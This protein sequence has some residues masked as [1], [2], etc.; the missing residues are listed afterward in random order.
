M[1]QTPIADPDDARLAPYRAVGDPELL[2]D[3]G[4]FAAEGRFVVERLLCESDYRV[5]SVLV[6]PASAN[7]LD[8]VLTD[9]ASHAPVYVCSPDLL[10]RITGFDFHRGC[11]ALAHRPTDTDSLARVQARLKH[12]RLVV[13][14][15][16]VSNADN[17]G[18]IIRNAEAFGADAVVLS[19]TSCDPLY[20]RAIRVSMGAVLR[21]PVAKVRHWP[22]VFEELRA[23][24][25]RLIALTPGGET[26]LADAPLDEAPTVMVVGGEG[27]G[28]SVE[29]AQL[30]DYRVRIPLAPH[31]D[32]L[33]VSTASGIALHWW[34]HR[35]GQ[36]AS[37]PVAGKMTRV[38][39]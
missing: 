15:D 6:S 16:G 20:R 5:H 32:S 26:V 10:Q 17:V 3:H 30:A 21:L 31:V 37:V 36:A 11:L 2:R 1:T 27:P 34:T 24:G 29:V 14:L 28:V 33:N 18:A 22:A 12:A 4:L 23:V 38:P 35:R 13:A 8:A 7:A 19:P 25:F 39:V 9:H